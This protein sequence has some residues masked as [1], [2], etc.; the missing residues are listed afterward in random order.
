LPQDY[1]CF[2]GYYPSKVH[3]VSVKWA[4]EI[5]RNNILGVL[6][7]ARRVEKGGPRRSKM[8]TLPGIGK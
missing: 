1:F 8:A 5:R 4:G 7:P 3:V 6:H 2:L